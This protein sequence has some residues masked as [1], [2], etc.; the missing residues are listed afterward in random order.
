MDEMAL[1]DF[2]RYAD[3]LDDIEGVS[4]GG[5]AILFLAHPPPPAH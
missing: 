1:I 3:I 4:A 2:E 5:S